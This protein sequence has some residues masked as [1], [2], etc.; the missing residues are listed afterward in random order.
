MQLPQR[1][2]ENIRA[3]YPT[4]S[5][6]FFDALA[7]SPVTSVRL[8]AHKPSNAF[9]NAERVAWCREGRYLEERPSFIADPLLHAGAY[10][11]QESS[12]M[13]LEHVLQNLPGLSFAGQHIR[14]LDL[15]AAPGG[16][17][18]L[19]ASLLN[20]GSLLVSNEIIRSRVSILEENLMRWGLPNVMITNNDPADF[21][22][23]GEFFDVVVVD[24]PCSGEG[25]FRKDKQATKEWSEEAVQLCAARQQRI[26]AG[27]LPALKPGGF[28]VYSTCT[29]NTTENEDNVKW[30]MDELQM[31][32]VEIKIPGEWPIAPACDPHIHGWRFLPHKV[33]GEGLFMAVLRKTGG[34]T[35][36]PLRSL[37]LPAQKPNPLLK[38]AEPWLDA[39][40]QFVVMEHN[41][42]LVAMPEQLCADCLYLG[43][44][45]KP[46]RTGIKV[47][48]IVKGDALV[49]D[50]HL[51]LSVYLQKDIPRYE[52]SLHEAQLYLRKQTFTPEKEL[53]QG[54]HLI[55]YQ[56]LGLGWIKVLEN[57]VNNYLPPEFRILKQL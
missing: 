30:L 4:E 55:T 36:N 44:F 9:S 12:S 39:D 42:E 23:V 3:L 41:N 50:H 11:V 25:L 21:S 29:F 33:R 52:A 56:G 40:T 28:L 51:A 6:Y 31:Q 53:R 17:S 20:A 37:K 13:F 7:A 32:P 35:N 45:L 5:G 22:S 24:A 2:E 19:I 10:Y 57:R 54:W 46:V 48:K 38:I 47:G 15:C 8:N 1:F 26:L 49:P 14:V 43:K 16:K 34:E 18:T 27:V